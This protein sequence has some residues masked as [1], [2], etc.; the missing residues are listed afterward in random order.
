MK[1]KTMTTMEEAA[2]QLLDALIDGQRISLDVSFEAAA[3]GV[4]EQL[5]TALHEEARRRAVGVT[6]EATGENR[7]CLSLLRP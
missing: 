1:T 7:L 3:A 2:S 5:M 6:I 4:P